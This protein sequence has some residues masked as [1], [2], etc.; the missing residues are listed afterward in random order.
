MQLVQLRVVEGA[1][2]L[3]DVACRLGEI[4]L[5]GVSPP[6]DGSDV[7]LG[8]GQGQLGRLGLHVRLEL[9]HL[10]VKGVHLLGEGLIHGGA[11]ACLKASSPSMS[12]W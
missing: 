4:L 6:L 1:M 5:E 2:H 7:E 9:D 11:W 8:S 12:C 10:G 3:L